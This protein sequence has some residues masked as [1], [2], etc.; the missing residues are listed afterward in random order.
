MTSRTK[1]WTAITVLSVTACGSETGN[2][3]NPDDLLGSGGGGGTAG[4]A[5][6][7][8]SGGPAS[9]GGDGG[10]T[11]E[12]GGT[13]GTGETGG[14]S[15]T[16][17]SGN[18]GMPGGHGGGNDTS[19]PPPV[20]S[21]CI[22]DVTPTDFRQY[23]CSGLRFNLSIPSACLTTACGL[24][25]DVHGMSM[26]GKMQDNNT[27]LAELGRQ[28]GYLVVNP[29][30]TPN[31]PAAAWNSN[32]T[33]DATVLDFVQQ[34]ISVFHADTKRVHITGY[35]QGGAM[36]WRFLCDHPNI[37]ASAAPAAFGLSSGTNECFSNG[38]PP[39]REVPILYMHGTKDALINFSNA[40]EARDAV[41]SSQQ[42]TDDGL[43]S[44]DG[45]HRWTRYVNDSGAIFEFLEH[46]YGGVFIA[47]GHC[48][49]GGNDPGGEPGQITTYSCAP[50]NAFHWG[51][52]VM[53]FF[54]AHPMP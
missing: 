26:S 46:D 5:A 38:Q 2:S 15:A 19:V 33:D 13:G 44:S 43:V 39:A 8:A 14:D 48:F 36:S 11:G 34:I 40:E 37:I 25:I 31:P 3:G 10:T 32:G 27:N 42:M 16:G 53:R 17:G 49:P 51:E 54:K 22:T 23:D 20:A 50:P 52:E 9:K 4:N 35:S 18:T 30:A 7:G 45:E 47:E 1:A 24:I 6:S 12:T 41:V 28:N 21:G 29:N